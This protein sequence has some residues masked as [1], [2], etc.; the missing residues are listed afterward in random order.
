MTSVHCDYWGMS[1]CNEN[2]YL[3]L[4]DS[5]REIRLT[6][7]IGCREYQLEAGSDGG[8]SDGCSALPDRASSR[9]SFVSRPLLQPH[10]CLVN[11]H[12]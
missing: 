4:R 8:S 9:T 1:V 7:S 5:R 6:L 2:V 10:M 12:D 3:R 11:D